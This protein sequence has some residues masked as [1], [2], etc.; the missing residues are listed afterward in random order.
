MEYLNLKNCIKYSNK[1]INK[2]GFYC[3]FLIIGL[4]IFFYPM[5]ISNFDLIPGKGENN[6]YFNYIL[7]HSWLWIKQNAPNYYLWSPPF[8]YPE[9]ST[10]A[11]SDSLIGIMPFYWFL[12]TLSF[13]PF[14]AFQI[15]F[16]FLCF[17]NYSA[18]YYLMNK[19]LNF[20][21]LASSVSS[22]IFA[23]SLMRYFRID[24]IN[25]YTQFFTILA[26]IFILKVNKNNSKMKNHLWFLLCAVSIILQ[27]YSCFTLGF[28]SVFIGFMGLIIALL[29]K[30]GRDCVVD[31]F[32]NYYKLIL[33]YT[34]TVILM[35][36]PL[37]YY[38]VCANR[39]NTYRE[40]IQNISNFTVWIRTLSI[41]DNIFIKDM[42]YIGYLRSNEFSIGVGIFTLILSFLGIWKI[43]YSKGVPIILLIFIFLISSSTSAIFLWKILYFLLAGSEIIESPA[44]ASFAALIILSYGIGVLIQFLQKNTIKN[45]IITK[46]LLTAA[47]IL[48]TTEQ[49]PCIKDKNSDWQ[50]YNKSIKEFQFEIDR[51]SKKIPKNCKILTL[52]FEAINYE[53]FGKKDILIKKIK[54]KKQENLLAMW[55]SLETNIRTTNGFSI[56]NKNQKKTTS[57][58]TCVVKDSFDLSKL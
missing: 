41:L 27:F 53:N 6:L 46:F 14:N 20:S 31:F 43:K 57:I 28:F 26:I 24:E 38:Y 50:N 49:I 44:R 17:L 29:P 3:L 39:I 47:I 32:K 7:E 8:Y 55:T 52:K 9:Q 12:R 45:S 4:I 33:F 58:N 30:T 40:I 37:S 10:M 42:Y 18:F 48:I 56:K 23:F 36:I 5:F 25:Y 11:L 15:L 19:E 2:Y 51:L 13:N 16:I 54:M 21:S 35:L 1:L 34:F 22:F